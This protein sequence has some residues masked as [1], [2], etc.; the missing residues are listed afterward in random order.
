MIVATAP[1]L[2][3]EG[4]SFAYPGRGVFSELSLRIPAGVT[5]VRGGDG[6]GKTTLLRLLAADLPADARTLRAGGVEHRAR[7]DDYQRQVFW[8]DPR[9]PTFDRLTAVE[10]LDAQRARWPAFD[11]ALLD[12][13][14]DGLALTPHA[15]KQLFM[16]STGSRRKV[17]LAA[18]F[19]SGALL[20]LLDDPFGALDRPSIRFVTALLADAA[21]DRAR[22]WVF[23]G[24]EAPEG[25]PLASVVDLGD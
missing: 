21:A 12:D 4:L 9:T 7:P 13:L 18:A 19:A 5:L 3:V 8:I 15:G 24:Y 2:E 11:A 17:W 14:I 6:R 10:F 20:T 23:S 16:L 22:A 1:L 25:V